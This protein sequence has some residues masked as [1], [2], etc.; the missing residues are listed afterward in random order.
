[1]TTRLDFYRQHY[2][3]TYQPTLAM[4][5]EGIRCNRKRLQARYDELCQQVE[6]LRVKLTKQA[7]E[8]IFGKLGSI[9]PVK[10]KKFFFETLGCTPTWKR[11]KTKQGHVSKT[12]VDENAVRTIRRRNLKRP[13]VVQACDDIL[14]FRYADARKKF[15]KPE[16]VDK[17]GRIRASYYFN[18]LSLRFG[19][20][21]NPLDS[22]HNLQNPPREE[23]SHFL[24]DRGHVFISRDLSQ[25]ESRIV[26]MLTGDDDLIWRAR[27][28]PT[29]Y[30]DHIDVAKSIIGILFR[31]GL[32]PSP[33]FSQLDDKQKKLL[34]FFGKTANHSSN[35][36]GTGKMMSISLL[37]LGYVLSPEICQEMIDAKMDARPA[38]KDVFQRGI[39]R[40]ITTEKV[41][42][43]PL[44]HRLDF[45]LA[46]KDGH[47]WR[48]GY[49][50]IPQSTVPMIMNQW[51]MV[52]L[53]HEIR[54]QGWRAKIRNQIH[55]D[56]L[57][58]VH[59]ED[60]WDVAQFLGASLVREVQ[61]PDLT[62]HRTPRSMAIPS[63]LKLGLS[64]GAATEWKADPS[65]KQFERV[66][67]GL[68]SN[69][70]R[71]VA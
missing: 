22:G 69:Q 14:L 2:R 28:T 58:S 10:A 13:E 25:A 31:E 6:E 3:A 67:E 45:T 15:C 16:V 61:Y 26:Y 36:A 48:Q 4:S 39:R 52:P 71:R 20:K 60:A 19:S 9:S 11:V 24:P 64:W 5:R 33:K 12:S 62:I 34:R 56:L 37:E 68:L 35:Y 18:T 66:L 42:R 30:D 23:R 27:A 50:F 44:G 57:V 49:M 55:D 46:H 17:D 54:E 21:K 65:R 41:L 47:C 63:T 7:G 1:M 70:E 51:G 32:V 38:I 8:D 53:Y 43:N 40:L 59:P 29:E